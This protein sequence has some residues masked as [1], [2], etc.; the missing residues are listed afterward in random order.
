[1]KKLRARLQQDLDTRR[2]QG[3]I[4]QLRP[5]LEGIDFC[6]NDYL[7]LSRNP[8]LHDAYKHSAQSTSHLSSTGSRLISGNSSAHEAAEGQLA[9]WLGFNNTLLMSTGYSAN[10][11]LLACL[12]KRGDTLIT[13]QLIHASLIDGVRLSRADKQIFKHN[14]LNDL[15]TKLELPCAGQRFVVVESVYSMDGDTAPLLSITELCEQFDAAL[16]VDEAHSIGIYG[17]SGAGIVAE[18]GLQKRVAACVYTFGKAAGCHGAAIASDQTLHEYLLN[19]CRPFIYSTA[20]S[21]EHIAHIARNCR[22]LQGAEQER[23]QLQENIRYFSRHLRSLAAF[24]ISTSQTPVQ[25]LMI[26][27]AQRCKE[28][29]AQLRSRGFDIYGITA[30]T[31][32][33]GT[34]RLRICLHS[35]N[36]REEVDA[37][38]EALVE[39]LAPPQVSHPCA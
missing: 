20:P 15:R 24:D 8:A 2:A 23:T 12:G 35:Y 7:G 36:T 26:P 39:L 1:M 34:E 33:A 18:L 14:D 5:Q 16:I 13:D 10:T 37:L 19:H 17:Q 32:P 28:V 31:V 11:G 38:G 3:M 4:R 29:A 22:Y 27:G 6:S 25:F 30:P 21:P 9:R